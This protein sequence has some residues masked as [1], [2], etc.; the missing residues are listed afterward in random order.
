MA[1]KTGRFYWRT[2]DELKYAHIWLGEP[3]PEDG[4]LVSICMTAMSIPEDFRE[5]SPGDK[6]SRCLRL[7]ATHRLGE[8][9]GRNG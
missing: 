4:Q 6:C 2:S 7:L 9:S 5:S 1:R 8:R 3:R